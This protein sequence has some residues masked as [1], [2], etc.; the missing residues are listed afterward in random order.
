MLREDRR[1]QLHGS[2][3]PDR[4]YETV[5]GAIKTGKYST[6]LPLKFASWEAGIGESEAA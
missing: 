2:L 3:R 6:V 1:R 4:L 5:T